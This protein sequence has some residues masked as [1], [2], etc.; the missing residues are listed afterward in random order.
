MYK[1][2]DSLTNDTKMNRQ[3]DGSDRNMN[4]TQK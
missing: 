3:I 4:M 1:T 2:N